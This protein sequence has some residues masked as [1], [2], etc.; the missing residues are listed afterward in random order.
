MD[1]SQDIS[2]L[3]AALAQTEL[4]WPAISFPEAGKIPG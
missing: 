4:S 1:I 3:L 2:A